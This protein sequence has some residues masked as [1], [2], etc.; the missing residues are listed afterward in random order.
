[1]QPR[2]LLYRF[3]LILV[4]MNGP[5]LAQEGGGQ[6]EID[7]ADIPQRRLTT[8]GQH[9][10]LAINYNQ[11]IPDVGLVS[12]SLAPAL[13]NDRFRTGDDYLRIQGLPWKGRHWN[14]SA[15]DFR[16]PGQ[17]LSVPFSNLYFPEIASR[18]FSARLRTAG[19]PSGFSM[20]PKP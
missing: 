16:L 8:G 18:G 13:S 11:F 6:A 15:G 20:A 14:F 1:M 17:L 2:S 4:G 7:S 3:A 10:G 12:A 5:L 19:G 9:L